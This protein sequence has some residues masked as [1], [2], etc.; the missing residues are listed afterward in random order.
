MFPG[1]L[2]VSRRA[3]ELKGPSTTSARAGWATASRSLPGLQ[4]ERSPG[5]PAQDRR[6]SLSDPIRA[7]PQLCTWHI[8]VPAGHGLG[9]QF[10]NFSLEAQDECKLDYVAVYETSDSGALGLLGR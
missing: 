8:S 7:L 1:W 6:R 9:L 3:E 4:Q 10:H 5:C 2:T